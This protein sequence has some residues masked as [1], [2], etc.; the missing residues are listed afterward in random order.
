MVNS[1]KEILLKM[2]LDHHDLQQYLHPDL[3]ERVPVKIKSNNELG[4]NLS[5]EKFG[6]PIEFINSDV[7]ARTVPM[8]EVVLFNIGVNK[9]LFE[10][11]YDIEGVTIK[12]EL[13]R[14]ATGW[15]FKDFEVF[16][17]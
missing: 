12:G 1:E 11:V 8:L 3:P 5:V 17:S 6:K 14:N 7:S 16:E 13:G 15:V 4:T 10:I 9:V 2:I